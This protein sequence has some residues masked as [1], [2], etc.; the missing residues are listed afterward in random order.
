MGTVGFSP[1]S[2]KPKKS[3]SRPAPIIARCII[4]RMAPLMPELPRRLFDAPALRSSGPMPPA[5]PNPTGGTF[6]DAAASSTRLQRVLAARRFGS[7]NA[8]K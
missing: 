1:R 2:A 4:L 8:R 3:G 6:A 7:E 5:P